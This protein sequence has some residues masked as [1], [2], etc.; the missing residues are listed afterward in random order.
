VAAFEFGG[1]EGGD[2]V[3]EAGYAFYA[4][5]GMLDWS[6]LGQ[7]CCLGEHLLS[8]RVLLGWCGAQEGR[9]Q[10]A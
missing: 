3:G 9:E 5:V 1:L 2:V 6:L 10:T 7:N 4:G 8:S